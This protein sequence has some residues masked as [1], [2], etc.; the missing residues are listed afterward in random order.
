MTHILLLIHTY[1]KK[2]K[3]TF[4]HQTVFLLMQ[5]AML[6]ETL[7]INYCL[8]AH[9]M[10]YKCFN[11]LFLKELHLIIRNCWF[12]SASCVKESLRV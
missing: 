10:G 8:S 6:F 4:L 7:H 2:F 1:T 12:P 5:V 9:H 3:I 11:I